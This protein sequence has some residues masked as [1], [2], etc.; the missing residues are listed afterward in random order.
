M[1]H[2][3][4]NTVDIYKCCTCQNIYKVVCIILYCYFIII[5]IIRVVCQE[6]SMVKGE[7]LYP[8]KRQEVET[9]NAS[10]QGDQANDEDNNVMHSKN[11]F[12]LVCRTR[13]T[14]YVNIV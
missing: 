10:S 11:P 1:F 2:I 14:P 7:V 5:I 8:P 12:P 9:G 4:V 6:T 13:R 3:K